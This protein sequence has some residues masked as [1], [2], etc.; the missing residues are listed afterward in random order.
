MLL[1]VGSI[2]KTLT[3]TL[4]VVLAE[5]G[6][7]SLD[8]RVQAYLPDFA[9]ANAATSAEVTVR[10]LLQHTGGWEGDFTLALGAEAGGADRGAM[11][12]NIASLRGAAVFDLPGKFF[13]YNNGAFE[14]C[15]ALVEAVCPGRLFEEVLFEEVIQPLGLRRTFMYSHADG[16]GES[17]LYSPERPAT[18]GRQTA[19]GHTRGAG[20]G[21]AAESSAEWVYAEP[22]YD[23]MGRGGYV[24]HL[25]SNALHPLRPLLCVLLLALR[26]TTYDYLCAG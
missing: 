6:V 20:D 14:A 15:G 22:W 26:D 16:E 24:R 25:T 11:A 18:A 21:D 19:V 5:R 23:P 3:A 17:H 2:S 4:V 12:R 10:H 9:L 13:S 7:L 1:Q 8:A